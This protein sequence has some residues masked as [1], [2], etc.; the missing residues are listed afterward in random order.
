MV[1]DLLARMPIRVRLTLGFAAVMVV[2]FGG[3]ALALHEAFSA[4]VDDGIAR[5]LRTRAADLTTLVRSHETG[6]A[7]ARPALP[8][9][10][11][12]YA[13]I[14]DA[15][16]RV[17]DATQ[18][19]GG[20][21]LLDRAEVARALRRPIVVGRRE[22]ARVRAQA[23]DVT[24]P[25]VLVVAVSLAQRDRALTTLSELL[26]IGGPL[27]LLVTCL[28][29]YALADRALAPVERM[30]A[31]AAMI[32]GGA[33]ARLPLPEAR[34]ELR[35]L[36]ET[37][38][39]MLARLEDA[40]VRERAFLANAGHELRTPLSILKLEIGLALSGEPSHEDLEAA[41]RSA[42]EEVER[43]ARLAD[44]L[45]VVARAAQGQLP[46]HKRPLEVGR[47]IGVVA[48]RIEEAARSRGRTV[49]A[50][51]ADGLV[52]SADGER[53]EQALTNLV[54][55]ALRHGDGPIVLRARECG[56]RVELH[57]LDEGEGFEPELLPAAFER[58]GT[59]ASRAGGGTGLGLSIVRAIAEA[60]G[61]RAAAANR[62]GGGADVWVS[63]P[64]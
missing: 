26:F 5:S 39:E 29:G 36:G 8:E 37:L 1:G 13:Q 24:P 45:L 51:R 56:D 2:L 25:S 35:R 23:L 34:D 55:N 20:T 62:E 33:R 17:L 50:E 42:A 19:H 41:L 47:V 10:E 49:V 43:L 16:G 22:G 44:D 15:R 61:G 59:V 27:L 31:R 28:A 46:V 18:G 64:R 60:H 38:N 11:G 12:A 48:D 63:L 32:S 54:V 58:S 3:L 40:L 30:R 14:L 7:T 52:V 21:P 4:S 53:L 6:G 9:S 57:V